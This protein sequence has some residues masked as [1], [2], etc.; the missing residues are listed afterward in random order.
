MTPCDQ[1]CGPR[2]VSS[3]STSASGVRFRGQ[4]FA[5]SR[6]GTEDI[7]KRFLGPLA[8]W[9]Q[10]GRTWSLLLTRN[11]NGSMTPLFWVTPFLRVRR[12][13]QAGPKVLVGGFGLGLGLVVGLGL[14]WRLL[15]PPA[16]CQLLSF[17]FWGQGS[18]TKKDKKEKKGYPYS[19]LSTGGPRLGVGLGLLRVGLS[20]NAPSGDGLGG[21]ELGNGSLTF[22]SP[23][24][25][26]FLSTIVAQLSLV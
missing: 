18:P 13:L 24:W 16:R 20:K 11:K 19:N 12:R 6:G 25:L 5:A 1:T 7:E 26:G 3:V 2:G 4:R 8:P 22:R 23:C 14:D 9:L 15:G 17:L 10:K 21:K